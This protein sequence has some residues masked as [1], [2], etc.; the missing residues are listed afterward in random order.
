MN[1][2]AYLACGCAV[3]AAVYLL[4]PRLLSRWFP[5]EIDRDT[6]RRGGA[7]TFA[8]DFAT[9]G[10]HAGV[11]LSPFVIVGAAG[12]AAWGWGAAL[13]LLAVLFGVLAVVH[14]M[15]WASAVSSHEVSLR[16]TLRRSLG[17]P[18]AAALLIVLAAFVCVLMSMV[19]YATAGVMVD[20][21]AL[22]VPVCAFIALA[23]LGALVFKPETSPTMQIGYTILVMLCMIALAKLQPVAWTPHRLAVF[24]HNRRLLSA[25]CALVI[26]LVALKAAFLPGGTVV[27]SINHLVFWAMALAAVVFAVGLAMAMPRV[28]GPALR[29]P[30][31]SWLAL[32][33]VVLI[34]YGSAGVLQ[35]L[36]SAHLTAPYLYEQRTMRRIC[37]GSLVA[38][39][40]CLVVFV[41]TAVVGRM[42]GPTAGVSDAQLLARAQ[43]FTDHA[44]ALAA[45]VIGVFSTLTSH[46]SLI[47]PFLFIIAGAAAACA[48]ARIM[49]ELAGELLGWPMRG[50]LARWS[51]MVPLV[52]FML[53]A[54][55]FAREVA[56]AASFFMQ[57]GYTTWQGMVNAG[58]I[59]G[60]GV[61][62]L[63]AWP[64][65]GPFS[66]GAGAA[67]LWVLAAVQRHEGRAFAVVTALAA[68]AT[69]VAFL[70][71]AVALVAARTA[72]KT[73]LAACFAAIATL[74]FVTI[75]VCVA[76]LITPRER[77]TESPVQERLP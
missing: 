3:L 9:F 54:T 32:Q 44:E 56:R 60:A 69:P 50:V 61:T 40:C 45:S 77:E 37:A 14:G 25:V 73:G 46:A 74:L 62:S 11:A 30:D 72:G 71:L 27:R 15:G 39:A 36:F 7:M 76:R 1:A 58:L 16:D 21:P 2:L 22:F 4:W 51:V 57:H 23:F 65:A 19:V 8:R 52:A 49:H 70:P 17:A 31:A 43:P 13:V 20:T 12:A 48:L 29:V 28:T 5:F 33:P 6:T 35:A 42:T 67:F 66:L 68:A 75:L 18:A 55:A 64:L 34:G 41:S 53:L 63:P 59:N 47:V 38:A 10:Q 26:Y 24:A